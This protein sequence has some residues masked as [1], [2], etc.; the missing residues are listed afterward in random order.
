MVAGCGMTC[1]KYILFLVNFLFFVLGVAAV[2]LGVYALVDKEDLELLAMLDSEGHLEKFNAV[3]L[4]QKGAMVLI[5][6]GTSLLVLGFLGCC[7]AVRESKCLLGLYSFVVII[8]VMVQIAAAVTAIVFRERVADFLKNGLK[9]ALRQHYDGS[10]TSGNPFSR[11][12][13]FA[14]IYFGCCGVTGATDFNGTKWYESRPSDNLTVPE[15]CCELADREAYFAS[16]KIVLRDPLCPVKPPSKNNTH[17]TEPCYKKIRYWIVDRSDIMIGIALGIVAV[18]I[19][20][21]I[22]ACRLFRDIE[23]K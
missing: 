6:G 5:A 11:A 13:D 7:G 22:M 19:L 10:V 12:F 15:A 2:A 9:L 18:E 1:V 8:I 14:Q 4:L 20:A 3:G 17:T 16:N 21:I 23:K